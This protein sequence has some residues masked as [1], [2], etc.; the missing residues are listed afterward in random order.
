MPPLTGRL[1][2][3]ALLIIILAVL[4]LG[5]LAAFSLSLPRGAGGCLWIHRG[6]ATY[7]MVN[8]SS[9]TIPMTIDPDLARLNVTATITVEANSTFTV[10]VW[11]DYGLIYNG[12]GSGVVTVKRDI[13]GATTIVI[14]V[15]SVDGGPLGG[16]MV[17]YELEGSNC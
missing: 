7:F 4:V 12:T 5:S 10:E 14:V 15:E 13:S 6:G 11:S 16:L 1:D 2:R 8:T 17:E 9:Y 3:D